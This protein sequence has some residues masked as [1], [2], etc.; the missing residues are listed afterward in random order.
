MYLDSPDPLSTLLQKLELNAEV[1]L[2]GSFC[3]AWKVDTSGSKRIP[4]HLIGR[5]SAWLHFEDRKPLRLSAGDLVIFP[6]DSSH[7]IASDIDIPPEETPADNSESSNETNT[8]MIC[9]FFEFKDKATLPVIDALDPVIV[10][11]TSNT[12]KNH[13]AHH[14]IKLMINELTNSRQGYYATTNTLAYLLFIEVI[15]HQLESNAVSH[16]LLAALFDK[17]IGKAMHSIHSNPEN[18]WSLESLANEATMGRTA[19]SQRFNELLG[20]SAMQYLG[21]WRMKEATRFL[22][23]TGLSLIQIAERC[24]YDSES[25]FSKAYK[26]ITGTTPG[27]VRREA[28]S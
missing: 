7:I 27:A 3:G 22:Q 4:F 26:K 24:G 12:H 5:G 6:F 8:H 10:M 2:N 14:L 15:R 19:F 20:M 25:S 23:R 21:Y 9:G 16:G 13:I 28:G 17:K 18:K 1:Y 11:D